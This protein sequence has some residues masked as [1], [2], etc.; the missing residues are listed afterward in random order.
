M[1]TEINI[2]KRIPIRKKLYK[3]YQQNK[4]SL[5]TFIQPT[6]QKFSKSLTH[7]APEYFEKLA[8]KKT[9]KNATL[10]GCISKARANSESKLTFSESSFNFRQY[11]VGSF[12]TLYP[13]EY[14]TGEPAPWNPRCRYQRLVRLKE[15]KLFLT[16]N[17]LILIA[18]QLLYHRTVLMS[19][20]HFVCPIIIFDKSFPYYRKISLALQSS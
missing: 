20:S 19:L 4:T 5:F 14:T 10:N 3:N 2:A 1:N 16:G 7:S 8:F 6:L 17:H 15:S 18:Y 12:C 13:C 9:T 11:R